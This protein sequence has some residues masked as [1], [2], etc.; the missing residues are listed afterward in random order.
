MKF[1]SVYVEEQVYD[2]TMAKNILA[3]LEGIP[4]SII[5]RYGEVFNRKAQNFRL[6][7]Q[8][9]A[10]ILARKHGKLILPAPDGYGFNTRPSYYFSHMLN[11]IYDCRYCFLQGMYNSANYVLFTNTNDFFDE[12]D[13]CV[14]QH[15]ESVVFYSG[16]D[17]DSLALEPLSNFVD[18]YIPWF[19]KHPEAVLE[20]RTK[21]TQIRRFFHHDPLENCVV[22]MSFTPEEIHQGFEDKVPSIEKRIEALGRLQDYGWPVALRFEP[23]IYEPGIFESYGKLFEMLFSRLDETRIHSVSSGMF[24]M[25]RNYFKKISSLYPDEPLF[26]REFTE[27]NGIISQTEAVEQNLRSKFEELLLRYIQND[28]YY[29]CG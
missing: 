23:L 19:A 8:S 24:R 7:K 2:S 9:P 10:L 18:Q 4:V 6:Q 25:P 17:S 28:N 21:S 26:Y 3:K 15:R 12:F 5:E 16:Y 14:N 22:A 13:Q 1:S 11:C 20:V 27:R 29:R